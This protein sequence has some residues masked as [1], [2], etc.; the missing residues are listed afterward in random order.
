MIVPS[1]ADLLAQ[2]A[3]AGSS[4]PANSTTWLGCIIANQTLMDGTV[5]DVV[6]GVEG[7]EEC[8]RLCRETSGGACNAWNFCA[9]PIT[10]RWPP[11]SAAPP[12]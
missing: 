8:C 7:A 3:E 9:G 2:A 10:C 1:D 5:V 4:D 6:D 11:C 12:W